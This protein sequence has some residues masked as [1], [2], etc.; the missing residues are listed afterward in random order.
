MLQERVIIILELKRPFS[1]SILIPAR[2]TATMALNPLN[3]WF[4][5]LQR[6]HNPNRKPPAD[7]VADNLGL[8]QL[9]TPTTFV[10]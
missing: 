5:D 6:S 1:L 8:N 3:S 2:S 10:S 7:I 4:S 9:I